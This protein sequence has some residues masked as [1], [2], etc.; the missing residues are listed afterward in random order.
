MIAFTGA[1]PLISTTTIKLWVCV[2]VCVCNVKKGVSD[3]SLSPL[4]NCWRPCEYCAAVLKVSS[5]EERTWRVYCVNR[6]KTDTQTPTRWP[7]CLISGITRTYSNLHVSTSSSAVL[8]DSWVLSRECHQQEVVFTPA[9][10]TD[11]SWLGERFHTLIRRCSWCHDRH[12]MCLFLLHV[13]TYWELVARYP[14]LKYIFLNLFHFNSHWANT[15][16]CAENDAA[17][18]SFNGA[19]CWRRRFLLVW[20]FHLPAVLNFIWIG[21]KRSGEDAVFFCRHILTL[22][23][24]LLMYAVFFFLLLLAVFRDLKVPQEKGWDLSISPRIYMQRAKNINQAAD[25]LHIRSLLIW[26]GSDNVGNKS[27]GGFWRNRPMCGNC[28][29]VVE[30][31]TCTF[32]KIKTGFCSQWN[33][34]N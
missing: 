25:A 13:C 17:P 33:W 26:Q 20:Y 34:T 10:Q 2:C 28:L 21:M 3:L 5:Q 23:F 18:R 8:I 15:S 6:Q 9:L 14:T 24:T 16:V 31:H 32:G 30:A 12:V 29:D 19:C 11:W 22:F 4:H 7:L 1:G 27:H